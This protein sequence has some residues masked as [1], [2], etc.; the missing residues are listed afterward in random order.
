MTDITDPGQPSAVVTWDEPEK[1]TDNSGSVTLTSNYQSGDAFPIGR[2]DVIYIATDESDN[3]A[4]VRF[5]LIV[6]GV[7]LPRDCGGIIV[8]FIVFLR[9]IF[10]FVV[11]VINLP[12]RFSYLQIFYH[13]LPIFTLECNYIVYIT[14]PCNVFVMIDTVV[15]CFILLLL[16]AFVLLLL[17]LV[18]LL[19]EL[20]LFRSNIY[21]LL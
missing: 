3:I 7:I 12:L 13:I 20:L 4:T 15:I 16:F 8:I 17:L 10:I 14:N 11:V 1:V 6:K 9:T 18:L 19:M 5:K 21:I 2:T